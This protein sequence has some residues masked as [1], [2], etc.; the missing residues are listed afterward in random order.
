MS[1]PSENGG[2]WG[3]GEEGDPADVVVVVGQRA[4]PRVLVLHN[5]A[6][7]TCQSFVVCH[8]IPE[9]LSLHSASA[10]VRRRRRR[11]RT[12]STMRLE[13]TRMPLPLLSHAHSLFH[14]RSRTQHPFH[15]LLKPSLIIIPMHCIFLGPQF[16]Q[17]PW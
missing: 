17:S 6:N 1:R 2:M 10:R 12:G 16:L 4:Q 14:Q 15:H 13:P 3:S 11:R 7:T 8:Q 5:L 9:K